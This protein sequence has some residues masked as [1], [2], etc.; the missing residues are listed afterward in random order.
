VESVT[1]RAGE[2]LHLN[3]EIKVEFNTE[4]DPLTGNQWTVL[5]LDESGHAVPGERKVGTRSVTFEPLPPLSPD[6]SDGSFQVD[7]TY[8]LHVVGFPKQNSVKSASGRVLEKGFSQEFRTVSLHPDGYPSPLLPVGI[9]IEPFRLRTEGGGSRLVA[10]GSG[11]LQIPFTLPVFPTSLSPESFEVRI[12]RLGGGVDPVSPSMVRLLSLPRPIDPY[13]GSTVELV[14]GDV[15]LVQGDLVAVRLTGGF[16]A[17]RDYRGRELDLGLSIPL[18]TAVEGDRIPLAE[19]PDGDESFQVPPGGPPSFHVGPDGLI[20]PRLCVEAGAG[21]LGEFRPVR[22]TVLR[23]GVPFDRGD[24]MLVRSQGPQFEFLAVD[25]PPGVTVRVVAEEPVRILACG[26]IRVG[27]TLR[28]E[29]PVATTSYT[30]GQGVAC[31]VLLRESGLTLLAAGDIAVTGEV[32]SAGIE[33]GASPLTMVAGVG[34]HLLGSIPPQTVLAYSKG[35]QL[36]GAAADLTPIHVLTSI[37]EGLPAGVELEVEGWSRWRAIPASHLG[38]IRVSVEPNPRPGGVEVFVQV[39]PP[40]PLDPSSPDRRSQIL[41]QPRTLPI[42]GGLDVPPGGFVRILL[43]ARIAGGAP[44]PTLRR[45][46]LLGN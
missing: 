25:I 24:G 23:P 12:F 38:P 16:H 4:I 2:R 14:L 32:V 7:R 5:V 22:D 43:R 35:V 15:D 44:L 18:W 9:G 42:P 45:I 30:T 27:G 46:Q 10:V 20:R 40:D 29:T 33:S 19:W 11:R 36:T 1:P 6:L 17:L 3:R 39:A 34:I 41:E 37:T 28:L 8:T 13:P 31:A 26:S 21:E